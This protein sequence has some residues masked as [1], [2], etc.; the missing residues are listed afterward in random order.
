[1][2]GNIFAGTGNGSFNVTQSGTGITTISS[3]VGYTGTT[4]VNAGTLIVSGGLAG[5]SVVKVASGGELNVNGSVNTSATISDSGILSGA[6]T[7]GN[8]TVLSGGTISPGSNLGGHGIGSIT[9]GNIQL[10]GGGI[11]KLELNNDGSTGSAG[12]NWDQL[13]FN[14]LDL[15]SATLATTPFVL[16]LQTLDGSGNNNPL[17]SFDPT[18][19][20]TWVSV[21]NF[22]SING[23]Y[24]AA[25]FSVNSANFL[26]ATNGGTFSVVLDTASEPSYETLDL[27]FTPVPEPGTWAMM[28]GGLGMLIGIQRIRRRKP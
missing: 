13:Y 9:A 18:Q 14:T 27:V 20:H 3:T 25:D 16:S 19:S 23:T 15:S 17:A 1:V 8:V 5:T 22:L 11:Y 2:S 6:G 12:T 24:S 26:N 4:S 21:L 10:Q 7:V 28:L